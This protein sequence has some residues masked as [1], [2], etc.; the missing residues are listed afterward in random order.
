MEEILETLNRLKG[1]LLLDSLGTIYLLKH[2]EYINNAGVVVTKKAGFWPF[3]KPVERYLIVSY[4]SELH[5]SHCSQP[6]RFEYGEQNELVKK[7]NEMIDDRS[8]YLNLQHSLKKMGAQ[9]ITTRNVKQINK[10]QS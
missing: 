1:I 4:I 7:V 10:T 8:R 9:I 6:R 2:Y 3:T 5:W